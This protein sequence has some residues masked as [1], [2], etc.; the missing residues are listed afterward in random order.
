MGR[1]L[2]QTFLTTTLGVALLVVASAPSVSA[3]RSGSGPELYVSGTGAFTSE[4]DGGV[5]MVAP[6]EIWLRKDT[7][8]RPVTIDV[9]LAAADGTLPAPGACEEA[10]AHFSVHGDE[11][12]SLELGG[13][14]SICGKWTDATYV[15]SHVFAGRYGVLDAGRKK[16]R[17][18]DGFFEV[19]LAVDGSA[20]A[21]AVDT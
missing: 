16:L 9:H 8:G 20:F 13:D 15:V 17:G 14:G 21:Y 12:T 3:G 2:I 1:R 18:S 19:G 4:P 10:T 6:G 5:R 7:D 11:R